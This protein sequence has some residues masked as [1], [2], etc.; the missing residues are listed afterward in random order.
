MGLNAIAGVLVL[1]AYIA[2]SKARFITR[3]SPPQLP[4]QA[5]QASSAGS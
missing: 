1:P 5:A 3:H 4:L 2:W